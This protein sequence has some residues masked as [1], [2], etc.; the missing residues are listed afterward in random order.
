MNSIISPKP[1]LP[2][3]AEAAS[4]HQNFVSWPAEVYSWDWEVAAQRE[5]TFICLFTLPVAIY[6][7]LAK[8]DPSICNITPPPRL[9]VH[10]GLPLLP[11]LLEE[12]GGDDELEAW[13]HGGVTE[14]K[15]PGS[16]HHHMEENQPPTTHEHR[17]WD[18]YE[19]KITFILKCH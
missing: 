7:V 17:H 18:L 5:T 19:G 9:V 4:C 11:S 15:E 12:R 14:Q 10:K 6:R 8:W 2:C 13:G 16:L 1:F 3:V